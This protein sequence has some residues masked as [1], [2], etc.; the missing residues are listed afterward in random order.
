MNLN[1]ESGALILSQMFDVLAGTE[2]TVSYYE[3]KRGASGYMDATLSVAAG[4]VTGADGTP[5]PVGAGPAASI[6]QTT[7]I[8][9]N[10]TLHSFTFTPITTQATLSF[11]NHYGSGQGDNDGVFLDNVRVTSKHIAT[12]PCVDITNIFG[13][14]NVLLDATNFYVVGTNNIYTVGTI[15]WSNTCGGNGVVPACATNWTFIATVTTGANVITVYGS[16]AAGNVASDSAT[17]NVVPESAAVVAAVA[18][19]CCLLAARKRAWANRRG[20]LTMFET[21]IEL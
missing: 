16:N 20:D 18:A 17:V 1:G 2:Y 12:W 6:V 8:N 4:T 5:V 9:D 15:W 13:T 7:A 11:G 3:R 10:W 21:D 19:W 14:I